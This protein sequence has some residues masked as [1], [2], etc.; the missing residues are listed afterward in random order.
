MMTPDPEADQLR[1]QAD[2]CRRMA[3]E[4]PPRSG[5]TLLMVAHYFEA[6]ARRID[7]LKERGW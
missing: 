7:R 1:Q 3:K 6:H 5:G 4:R 2:S